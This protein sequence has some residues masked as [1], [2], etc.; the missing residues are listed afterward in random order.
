[1]YMKPLNSSNFEGAGGSRRRRNRNKNSTK[2]RRRT[3]HVKNRRGGEGLGILNKLK[4]KL[5]N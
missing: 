1:M 3:R 4:E 5:G 2:R